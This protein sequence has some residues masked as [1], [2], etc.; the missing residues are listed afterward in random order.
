VQREIIVPYKSG[1]E[2]VTLDGVA[3]ALV[4]SPTNTTQQVSADSIIESIERPVE[5]PSLQ[6]FLKGGRN[7][8][9][10]VNDGARRTATAQ[11]LDAVY[12]YLE[13][14][15]FTVLIACGA[16]PEPT[17][18][19]L[20]RILGRN[21]GQLA[22][23]VRLHRSEHREEMT[24]VGKSKRGTEFYLNSL[25]VHADRILVITSVE[26]H[27]F[28]GFM[29]GRKSFIP[30]VSSY[31]TIV[32]NHRLAL[33]RM[34]R[35][36]SLRRNPVHHDMMDIFR[37]IPSDK[38]F[39]IHLLQGRCGELVRILSGDI[40]GTFYSLAE[41]TRK[42]YGVKIGSKVDILVSV[43]LDPSLSLYES[44]KAL[45]YGML[46]L[47]KGGIHIV[48]S[49][50]TKGM[51]GCEFFDFISHSRTPESLA[52][53]SVKDFELGGQRLMKWAESRLWGEVWLVSDLPDRVVM[54]AFLRP[55]HSVRTAVREAVKARG[56]ASR[57]AFVFD[58]ARVIPVPQ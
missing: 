15:E 1:E 51:G 19:E 56:K 7:V 50:C 6:R 4:V 36:F 49:P 47:K 26:P 24:Y 54:G 31:E 42:L 17:R 11:I 52:D 46:G 32:Q 9:V 13:K 34:A 28:A 41:S 58:G 45:H 35:T 18:D 43:V 29:G 39:V 21:V 57:I 53:S 33:H 12:P 37:F 20:G 10:I 40:E 2:A 25:A 23:R 44:R 55:Y 38:V 30:G 22:D 8:V 14:M 3:Q 48:V 5:K 16:H 27:Y